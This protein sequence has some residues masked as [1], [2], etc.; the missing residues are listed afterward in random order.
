MVSSVPR[1][2]ARKTGLLWPVLFYCHVELE[3]ERLKNS[4][5]E[6]DV[7]IMLIRR[8]RKTRLDTTIIP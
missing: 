1:V 5:L 3:A 2:D 7:S 4:G 8:I 6:N